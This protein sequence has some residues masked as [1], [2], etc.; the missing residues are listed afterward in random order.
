MKKSPLIGRD[1]SS[2]RFMETSLPFKG[3]AGARGRVLS[4]AL[5][6][7]GDV[8]IRISRD[9]LLNAAQASDRPK[10]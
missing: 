6:P 2:G 9:V 8:R 3:T 10:K 1:A 7:D 5:G 4:R